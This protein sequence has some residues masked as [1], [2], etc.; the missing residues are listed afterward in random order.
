MIVIM[1]VVVAEE[2][3]VVLRCAVLRFT[4]MVR[5]LVPRALFRVQYSYCSGSPV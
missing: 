5:V 2:E 4:A 1:M 3:E